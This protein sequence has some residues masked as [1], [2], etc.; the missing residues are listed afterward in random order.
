MEIQISA[1][2]M[3][4]MLIQEECFEN[5]S[6]DR[7]KIKIIQIHRINEFQFIGCLTDFHLRHLLQR[8]GKSYMDNTVDIPVRETDDSAWVIKQ[9]ERKQSVSVQMNS[10]FFHRSTNGT[11]SECFLIMDVTG[12]NTPMTGVFSFFQKYLSL[13]KNDDS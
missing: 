2:G 7:G 11:L 5:I 4:N 12:Y 1:D 10:G 13:I 6:I 3:K 9:T 8:N